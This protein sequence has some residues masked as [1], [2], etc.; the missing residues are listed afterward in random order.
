MRVGNVGIGH[1]LPFADSP[2][3]GNGHLTARR[4]LTIASSLTAPTPVDRTG[5]GLTVSGGALQ[6]TLAPRLTKM[7][8]EL[9]HPLL[10]RR[11]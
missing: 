3:A 9:R 4:F 1:H 5:T 11:D 10:Y 6:T 2:V 8:C 7:N